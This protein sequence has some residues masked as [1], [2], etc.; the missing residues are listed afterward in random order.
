MKPPTEA[1]LLPYL[2]LLCYSEGYIVDPADIICLV[3]ILGR[4]IRRLI[5]TLEMYV[6]NEEP[7]FERYLSIDSTS[8][9]KSKCIPSRVAVDTYRLARYRFNELSDTDMIEYDDLESIEK[10]LEDNAFIDTWLGYKENGDM[11]KKK[12]KEDWEKKKK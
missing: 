2:W 6:K 5:Q 3:A 11:V 7:I 8:N 9:I 1:E 12:K 4:D 10:A